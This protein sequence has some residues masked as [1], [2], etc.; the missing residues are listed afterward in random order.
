MA[1]KPID[2]LKIMQ[3]SISS[4][5]LLR[6]CKDNNINSKLDVYVPSEVKKN[7]TKSQE[8]VSIAETQK[9]Q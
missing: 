7:F 4:W 1:I 8:I 6:L 9:Y 2:K 5:I 3:L